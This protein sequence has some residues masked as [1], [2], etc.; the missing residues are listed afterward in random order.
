MLG[1]H[2]LGLILLI[3]QVRE[4]PQLLGFS[5]LAYTLGLR[6]AFD[7]DHIASIDN[8]VRKLIQQKENPCGI[9]FFFSI[10]HSSVVFLMAT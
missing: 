2:L 5:F 1:I 6:R 7:A 8:T 4:Y 10:C 9:G 3:P